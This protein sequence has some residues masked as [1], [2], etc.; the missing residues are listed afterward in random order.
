MKKLGCTLIAAGGYSDHI[1]LLSVVDRKLSI[2]EFVSKVKSASSFWI[3]KNIPG[4]KIFAWQRGYSSF[5]VSKSMIPAVVR[6]IQRQREH[7]HR[8]GFQDELK[9]LLARHNL[10]Y[11]ERYLWNWNLFFPVVPVALPFA[12]RIVLPRVTHEAAPPAPPW[13]GINVPS[14][15]LFSR[16]VAGTCCWRLTAPS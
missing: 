3:H 8:Q 2:H 14:V 5:S 10:K 9:T 4:M 6:Y 1:H 15:R 11:D 7:H 12:H 13:A 16:P